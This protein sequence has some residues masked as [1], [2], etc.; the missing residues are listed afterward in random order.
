MGNG[1]FGGGGEILRGGMG[2]EMEG[3]GGACVALRWR[4]KHAWRGLGSW[5]GAACR[6]QMARWPEH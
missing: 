3:W 1:V 5:G 4:S 6:V 2:V